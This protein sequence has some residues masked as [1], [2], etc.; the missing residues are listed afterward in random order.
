MTT[1]PSRRKRIVQCLAAHGPLSLQ[2]IRA[3]IP[4]ITVNDLYHLSKG[5]CVEYAGTTKSELDRKEIA[6]YRPT[7]IGIVYANTTGYQAATSGKK[8]MTTQEKTS[9]NRQ[10]RI[11]RALM[12]NG[13]LTLAGIRQYVNRPMYVDMQELVT[14]GYVAEAGM[15]PARGTLSGMHVPV[16][17]ST[18]AGAAY[19]SRELIPKL[20]G[21]GK[22]TVERMASF[23]CR[24]IP[25]ATTKLVP[26]DAVEVTV[27]ESTKFTK[28]EAKFTY[29]TY[30]QPKNFM[31]CVR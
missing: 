22:K 3:H 30:Q 10:Q 17:K 23:N 24:T 21:L 29:Q 25:K 26:Q 20:R 31:E 16:Y 14:A 5:K 9:G 7:E 15:T 28:Y 4:D 1:Q 27:T 18:E 2:G 12:L 8:D 13:P 11:I 19:A 6:T